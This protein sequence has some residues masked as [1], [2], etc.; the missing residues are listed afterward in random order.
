MGMVDCIKKSYKKGEQNV[1]RDFIRNRSNRIN[2]IYLHTSIITTH[3]YHH[4]RNILRNHIR[5]NWHSMVGICDNVL[6]NHNGNI[7]FDIK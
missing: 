6:P 5:I 2:N 4:I 1:T 3:M 7:K